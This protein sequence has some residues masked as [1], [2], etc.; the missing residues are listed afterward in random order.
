[1]KIE[2]VDTGEVA[3]ILSV[4]YENKVKPLTGILSSFLT[5]YSNYDDGV[6]EY[7]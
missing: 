3:I 4:V 2:E 7:I 1:M 5:R 6:Q